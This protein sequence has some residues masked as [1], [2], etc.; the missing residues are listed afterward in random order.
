MMRTTLKMAGM[1]VAGFVARTAILNWNVQRF[2]NTIRRRL[3]AIYEE[4]AE[5]MRRTLRAR[6]MPLE[7]QL[8]A[9][10]SP[11][12]MQSHIR[13]VMYAHGCTCKDVEIHMP[14]DIGDSDSCTVHVT[15]EAE[16]RIGA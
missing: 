15:H 13:G 16:C 3:D 6:D 12:A 7:V 14:N 5:R 10:L 8:D 11:E 4:N 2:E 9:R 1:F